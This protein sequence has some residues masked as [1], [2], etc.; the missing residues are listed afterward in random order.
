MDLNVRHSRGLDPARVTPWVQRWKLIIK[1]LGIYW[2]GNYGPHMLVFAHVIMM[3]RYFREERNPI[4]I[5]S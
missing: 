2:G 4:L 3:L 5:C 1:E